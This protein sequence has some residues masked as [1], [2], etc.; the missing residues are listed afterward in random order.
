[1]KAFQWNILSQIEEYETARL[2]LA[3]N[4]NDGKKYAIKFFFDRGDVASRETEVLSKIQHDSVIEYKTVV[5]PD[6]LSFST[7]EEEEKFRSFRF[8]EG[9]ALEY[10]P[11]GDLLSLMQNIQMLPEIVARTFIS[12]LVDVL[13]YLHNQEH[14]AHNALHLQNLLLDSQFC[15]KLANFEA[16]EMIQDAKILADKTANSP[17][18]AFMEKENAGFAADMFALGIIIFELI[19]GY[20]PFSQA[21]AVED[22]LYALILEERW[23]EFWM[24][25]EEICPLNPILNRP[26]LQGLIESLLCPSSERRAKISDVRKSEWMKMTKIDKL[27]VGSWIIE[28]AKKQ[29]VNLL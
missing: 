6:E 11:R 3:E 25:H 13:E 21:S 8:T 9:Y 5:Y 23:E 7:Q 20:S 10:A 24:T 29:K 2:F 17:P 26:S 15:L 1:M 14:I 27:N 18:T 4:F 16:S 19:C 12:Q 22:E 28:I